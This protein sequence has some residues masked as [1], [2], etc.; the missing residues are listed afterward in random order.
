VVDADVGLAGDAGGEGEFVIEAGWV[1]VAALD[2]DD[3]EMNSFHF[4]LGVG[5]ATGAQELDAAHFE[6]LKV[7]AVVD[8]THAVGL[9]VAY[10][11]GDLVVLEH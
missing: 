6:V 10:F 4:E 2:L 8:H 11:K 3:D 5:D 7:T 1:F 9:R